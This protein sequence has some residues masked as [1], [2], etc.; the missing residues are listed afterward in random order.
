VND[1]LIA[2]MG[3]AGE[4]LNFATQPPAVILMAGLQGAGKAHHCCQ[5]ARWIKENERRSVI[6]ASAD[7]YR[8]A[9]ADNHRP[10]PLKSVCDFFPQ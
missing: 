5:I 1:E 10:W 7:V 4:K 9:A 3:M 2:I 8:P 6:V